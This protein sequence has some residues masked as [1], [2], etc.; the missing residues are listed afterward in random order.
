MMQSLTSFL[1]THWFAA[2]LLGFAVVAIVAAV[3]VHRRLDIW[4]QPLV[5]LLGGVAFCALGGLLLEWSWDLAFWLFVTA[6][7][8]VFLML[9]VLILSGFWSRWVAYPVGVLFMFAL[10]GVALPTTSQGLRDTAH[11]VRTLEFVE[12]WWLLV[13]LGE[14]LVWLLAWRSLDIGEVIRRKRVESIRPWLAVFLRTALVFFVALALAEPRV[15]QSNEN[16][17]VIFV[18]DRSAS[19][20]ADFAP[21]PNGGTGQVD[22]RALRIKNFINQSVQQRGAGHERDRCGLVVF[23]RKPRLELP[24]SDAPKFNLPELPDANDPNYTDIAAALKLALASFPDDT[25][26]RIVLIS[27]GNENLGNAEE[28]AAVAKQAGVQIDVLPLAAGQR[29][30]D[31][32]LI[33]RV[34]APPLTEQGAQI[35]I[36]VLVRSYNPN[37]V[38]AQLTLKQITEGEVA[39]VGKPVVVKLK[40]GLN[41]FAF[42]RP[43]TDEQRSYTYEAEIQ[44]LGVKAADADGE[45]DPWL[46]KGRLPGDRVENNRASTHVVARGQRR[47]LILEGRAGDHKELAD[48]LALAGDKK[49]KVN[50]EP[51]T[52]LNLYKD[53]DK[54]AVYL[55]NFD[56]VILANVSADQVTEEQ[57]EAIRT[58]TRDQGCGLVMIGGPDSFGAGGWQNTPVEKALPVDSDIKSLKV[59]GKGGLVLIMHASEMADGNMWQKKIAKLAVD[60]LGPADEFGVIDFGFQGHGWVIPLQEVGGKKEKMKST[61]DQMTPG[62]MPDFGPAVQ[63]AHDAL[64]DPAKNLSV[65]HVIIISDGDPIPPAGNLLA[66]MKAAKM[67]ITTVGVATHGAPQ[68]AAMQSIAIAPGKY[69]KVT[70][71]TKLPAIY[72]KESRIVSQSFVQEKQF[73]PIVLFTGGPTEKLPKDVPDLRGFVRTTPKPS[74]LVEIPVI[75]PKFADQDFPLLAYWHYGLGKSVAFTSDA[76]NPRFWSKDWLEGGVYGKFWEQLVDW[77]LRPTESRRLNMMTEYRDGKI[78]IVVEARDDKDKPDTTL[79][80][81]GGISGPGKHGDEKLEF[82]QKNS[83]QYELE[84]KAEDAGSYFITAQAVRTKKIIGRDGKEVEVEEGVDSVRSGVTVPYSPEF[85]DQETNT[86]LLDALRDRTD[87]KAY[88][89]DDA[90]LAK[91]IKAG[92]VFRPGVPRV[93]SL[94]PLWH[95]LLFAT[96]VLLFFDIAVRRLA[97]DTPQVVTTALNYWARLRGLPIRADGQPEFMERLQTRKQQIT[98]KETRTRAGQR[99]EGSGDVSLPLG[100]D[101]TAPTTTGGTPAQRPAAKQETPPKPE[102]EVGDYASRLMKAKKK[103]LDQQRKP[104]KDK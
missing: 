73:K 8:F 101:A 30:E 38:I 55:S 86:S 91:A 36:R 69:Y 42:K 13:L 3:L 46:V 20:P 104:D 85:A 50:V 88:E 72:I 61:I 48:R 25:G 28:V 35:P 26:K 16:M 67:T 11:S 59:Q 83:G 99:F 100:A 4:F 78:K 95:W 52:V 64:A 40:V 29:N 77:S 22:R 96:G 57:Q 84:I 49:F 97:L 23:G 21:D 9:L 75:T 32:V 43:L 15:R 89:D 66:K 80:L 76:G 90:A 79:K 68:D 2:A 93:K 102:E 34:E 60:R 82:T 70:D 12:P 1:G 39:V 74:P 54:L 56:C 7:V 87:G 65:K 53:A 37:T 10:G 33:E 81:K 98:A 18:L 103:A 51:I 44:P 6:L 94:L 92:D 58:N 14:P 31:E 41:T 47:I 63:M 62:D 71:P 45:A 17:T 24:P 27:D 5:V 19:I